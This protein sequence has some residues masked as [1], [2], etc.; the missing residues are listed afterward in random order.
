[1]SFAI[2][3]NLAISVESSGES[4]V[5]ESGFM[6]LRISLALIVLATNSLPEALVEIIPSIICFIFPGTAA[7]LFQIIQLRSLY[8]VNTNYY[9]VETFAWVKTGYPMLFGKFSLWLLS[10]LIDRSVGVI[11]YRLFELL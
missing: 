9:V 7:P 10:E 4:E 2:C 6:P 5:Y 1:M 11:F 3:S 8:I